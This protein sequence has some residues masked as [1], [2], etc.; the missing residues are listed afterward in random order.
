MHQAGHLVLHRRTDTAC[1]TGALSCSAATIFAHVAAAAAA[2]IDA[3]LFSLFPSTFNL[4][5]T[6]W[7]DCKVLL[8]MR[9]RALY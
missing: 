4:H 3:V 8:F 9:A 5:L 2:A 1:A 6:Q 7:T